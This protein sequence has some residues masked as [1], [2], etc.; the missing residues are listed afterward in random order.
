MASAPGFKYCAK[1]CE[2]LHVRVIA[3]IA[4]HIDR[5]RVL[6]HVDDNLDMSMTVLLLIAHGS[7]KAAANDEIGRLAA[8][9]EA[10]ADGEYAAV[11]PAFLEFAE[12]DIHCGI[13]RCVALGA[14]RIVALPY[15][16]AG[17][18]HVATDIP[19]ELACARAKYPQVQI[20]LAPHIGELE[21]MSR[22]VLQSAGQARAPSR[23]GE[24]A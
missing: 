11:V 9:I 16:L 24:R 5:G 19:L 12:P 22:L 7:R 10:D 2:G 23:E 4:I 3:R 18:R 13:D 15:F 14:E 21:A 20:D 17:G 6:M 1:N 8:R